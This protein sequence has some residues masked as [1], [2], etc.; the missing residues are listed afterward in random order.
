[1][2]VQLTLFDEPDDEF[3]APDFASVEPPAPAPGPPVGPDFSGPAYERAFD[4]ARLQ[5]QMRRVYDL[6]ADGGWR[7]LRE[8][9]AATGDPESSVSA[10]LRHLRKKKFGAF[11][12]GRRRRGEESRGLW[13]Y[14]LDTSRREQ[15]A[16]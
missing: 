12:V 4:L 9:A 8:I 15:E 5:A 14:Q 13:E 7:T 2:S 11:A 16:A 6:M 10:Q 3:P 1:V